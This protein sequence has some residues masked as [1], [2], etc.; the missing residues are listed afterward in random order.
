MRCLWAVDRLLPGPAAV[1]SWLALAA[2]V[3]GLYQE[4]PASVNP[5]ALVRAAAALRFA[6]TSRLLPLV[7]P[8]PQ[9]RQGLDEPG[10]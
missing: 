9:N 7:A 6:S 8:E 5:P 3:R 2:C 4:Q 10:A 1:L